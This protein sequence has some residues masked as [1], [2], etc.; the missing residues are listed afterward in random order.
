MPPG[1][2][3]QAKERVRDEIGRTELTNLVYSLSCVAEV[4]VDGEDEDWRSTT[5]TVGFSEEYGAGV[6]DTITVM[7]RAG[8]RVDGVTFGNYR[9]LEFVERG[10]DE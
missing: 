3:D 6:D 10:H 1:Q 9:R 5:I 2:Y 4:L 7:Q 8:W